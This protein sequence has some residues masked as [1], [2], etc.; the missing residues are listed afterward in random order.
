ML[1]HKHHKETGVLV[2]LDKA[3]Q[4]REAWEKH[5]YSSTLALALTSAYDQQGDVRYEEMVL[6]AALLSQNR[7]QM[8]E[9]L[10]VQS[11]SSAADD[12]GTPSEPALS[13][14]TALDEPHKLQP[15]VSEA[16]EE[17]TTSEE[18]PF[19]QQ[20]LAEVLGA[21]AALKLIDD[22]DAQ[23]VKKE[24]TDQEHEQGDEVESVNEV[25]PD[26]AT[27]VSEPLAESLP[28][29][30]SFSAWLSAL[31]SDLGKVESIKVTKA[32]TRAT[33]ALKSDALKEEKTSSIIDAFI[34][35][36][37]AIVPKRATF[38]SPTKAAKVSLE[39]REEIVSETLASVYAAQGNTSKAISTY[40]KLSLLHPEKSSYFAALIQ[41]LKSEKKFKT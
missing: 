39:D 40:E 24:R 36:E 32:S 7:K 12:S 23:G 20:F 11:D 17:Q 38:F 13:E 28:E 2:D 6:R 33:E 41:K 1:I 31:D 5:P 22:L 21:G 29:K 30:L 37:S 3:T 10:F 8:H 25:N 14:E 4:L 18:D 35:N 15:A 27:P 19:E 26:E 9:F 34:Q 16:E